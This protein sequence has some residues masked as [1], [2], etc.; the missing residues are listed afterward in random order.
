MQSEECA[1]PPHLVDVLDAATE[2]TPNQRA[3]AA[4]LL[5]KHVK[6]FPAPGTPITGRTD[7][8]MH[9]IEHWFNE[10]YKMQSEKTVS[11]K[12]QDTAGIGG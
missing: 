8:V 12:D 10:T 1:L 6:T 11:E 3:R 9:D 7:A 4:H 5:A 2:L